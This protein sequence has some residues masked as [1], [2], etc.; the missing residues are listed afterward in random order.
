MWRTAVGC[1]AKLN[2]PGARE[3]GKGGVRQ[4]FCRN[5]TKKEENQEA[6]FEVMGG[7]PDCDVWP[8]TAEHAGVASR[9]EAVWQE[10]GTEEGEGLNL[11]YAAG[12][13][14]K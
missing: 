1:R 8:V 12:P 7:H 2:W 6:N 5:A 9:V 13:K 4:G 14:G 11:A 10:C 3:R